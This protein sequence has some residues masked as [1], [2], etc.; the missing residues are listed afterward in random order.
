MDLIT[1]TPIQLTSEPS[2]LVLDGLVL[3]INQHE[4]IRRSLRS[5]FGLRTRT[6]H[7]RVD[8]VMDLIFLCEAVVPGSLP[9]LAVLT[10]PAITAVV[11]RQATL[12]R[13]QNPNP[14]AGR[15]SAS[16]RSLEKG[17]CFLTAN[18]R[19][20]PIASFGPTNVQPSQIEMELL[21]QPNLLEFLRAE[22][23]TLEI[24]GTNWRRLSRSLALQVSLQF[25]IRSAVPIGARA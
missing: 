5:A 9:C 19:K 20:V 2:V 6:L 4:S 18:S 14:V 11:L 17:N 10:H 8:P 22:F 23:F 15:G 25:E 24:S 1:S 3:T 21:G 7:L 12:T 13:I 16:L